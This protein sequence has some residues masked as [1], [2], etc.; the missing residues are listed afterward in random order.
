MPR[1]C[2]GVGWGRAMRSQSPATHFF[3]W[4]PGQPALVIIIRLLSVRL[5]F[6]ESPKGRVHGDRRGRGVAAVDDG[7]GT[8]LF[9]A[10]VQ[11]GNPRLLT[12]AFFPFLIF[13]FAFDELLQSPGPLCGLR[14]QI[15]LT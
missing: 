3:P 15:R 8:R 6:R 10:I 2:Q 5:G 7:S 12:H 14:E 11:P 4:P 9:G 13:C 1:P